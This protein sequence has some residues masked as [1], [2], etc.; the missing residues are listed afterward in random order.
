MAGK[1]SFNINLLEFGTEFPAEIAARVQDLAIPLNNII[2][3]WCGGNEDKFNKGSGAETGGAQID[4]DVFWYPLMS[5]SYVKEKR[6]KGRP[7][8]L[9]VDTGELMAAMVDP[10]GTVRMVGPQDA[11]FGTPY[12]SD[13]ET[14]ITGNW[15]M[16][17]VVFLSKQ[18]QFIIDKNITDYFSLGGDYKEILFARG[19]DREAQKLS[20]DA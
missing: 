9:M 20:H 11:V 13:N 14:K 2:D 8:W 4:A 1:V 18:D 15:A 6:K 19:L 5:E 12:S 3:A 17:Q 10:E 7:D 16:R